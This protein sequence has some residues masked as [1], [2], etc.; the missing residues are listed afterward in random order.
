MR[1]VKI[2]FEEGKLY[3]YAAVDQQTGEVVLRWHDRETLVALCDRLGWKIIQAHPRRS[4][5]QQTI[6]TPSDNSVPSDRPARR[7]KRSPK[8]RKG[9]G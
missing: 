5:S 2:V 3:S 8:N 1:R 4:N 6:M 7:S 9:I